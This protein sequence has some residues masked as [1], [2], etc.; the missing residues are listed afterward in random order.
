MNTLHLASASPRRAEILTRA[1]IP[2]KVYPQDID[3]TF[4]SSR[5]GKEAARLAREKVEAMRAALPDPHVWGLGADT[6]VIPGGRLTGTSHFLGKPSTREEAREMLEK[7]SGKNQTVIT[8]LA[9]CTPG[10]RLIMAVSKTRVRFAALSREE[11]RWYLD[12][13]EWRGAAG[14]YKIQGKGE[15]LVRWIKGSYSN[16]M[17]LPIHLLYGILLQ[18][19]YPFG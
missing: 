13:E 5:P 7:L 15:C 19:Q 14:A 2:F 6:F 8:G 18:H 11:I 16:V 4:I 1:G 3:E 12:S 17:G 10:D 9:V